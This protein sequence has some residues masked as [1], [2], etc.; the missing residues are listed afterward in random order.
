LGKGGVE[1]ID[2]VFLGLLVE[3]GL[4][5]LELVGVLG[6]HIVCLRKI[7]RDVVELPFEVI[8]VGTRDGLAVPVGPSRSPRTSGARAMAWSFPGPGASRT[9]TGSA[10]S[11]ATSLTS[12][13]R[14][15]KPPG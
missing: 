1:R 11:F 5:F 3:I 13:R 12:C 15:S 7:I 8:R 6:S 2:A 4:E 14:S 10:A 9:R